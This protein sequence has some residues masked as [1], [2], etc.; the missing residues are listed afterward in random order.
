MFSQEEI[1]LTITKKPDVNLNEI[2]TGIDPD[3]DEVQIQKIWNKRKKRSTPGLIN[4]NHIVESSLPVDFHVFSKIRSKIETSNSSND[5]GEL[6][7]N[8][9]NDIGSYAA[10]NIPT[11]GSIVISDTEADADRTIHK[12]IEN[13]S[14]IEYV[15]ILRNLRN[16][17]TVMD[18][19][20]AE[21][22]A[23][24]PKQRKDNNYAAKLK[25]V[26]NNNNKIRDNMKNNRKPKF[27]GGKRTPK[28]NIKN[29]KKMKLKSGE[30]EKEEEEEYF[31]ST[32]ED[33]KL[34]LKA[35]K[36]NNNG[37][38]NYKLGNDRIKNKKHQNGLNDKDANISTNASQN[39]KEHSD[40]RVD[41]VDNSNRQN[42]AT[43]EK[44]AWET[45]ELTPLEDRKENY[46]KSH[47]NLN[48]NDLEPSELLAW[49]DLSE[50]DAQ[51]QESKNI[52]L[53]KE[54]LNINN[55]NTVV[56]NKEVSV[57]QLNDLE[58]NNILDSIYNLN[59]DDKSAIEI[60]VIEFEKVIE[61]EAAKDLQQSNQ[62]TKK[63]KNSEVWNK[64]DLL[65]PSNQ[66]Q[67][68]WVNSTSKIVIDQNNN[69]MIN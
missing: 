38:Q 30:S 69:L 17:N 31:K 29:F 7:L 18:G 68:N 1:V 62:K 58:S 46:N 49:M 25:Q 57:I 60:S 47:N 56:D 6:N 27:V 40:L 52:N 42:N 50:V 41:G 61:T 20:L 5:E 28:P 22:Q 67:T 55:S 13:I 43:K 53:N 10:P 64:V 15:N 66:P 21:N 34:T 59:S 36:E 26:R 14:Q 11:R 33:S 3:D 23:K 8:I 65:N 45:R 51:S 37:K 54:K 4:N 24:K 48:T 44:K 9:N 63:I 19:N 12:P 16:K 2:H 32:F 35:T 39:S